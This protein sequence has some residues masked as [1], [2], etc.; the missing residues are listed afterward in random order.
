MSAPWLFITVSDESA[1]SREHL[2]A[3][4]ASLERQR[5]AGDLV[6]VMRGGNEAHP[7]HRG[8]V[9]V[10]TVICPLRIGA[11]QARNLGLGHAER[12]G[13]LAACDMVALPDDDARYPDGL[14]SHVSDLLQHKAAIVCGP[15]APN[16]NSLDVRR[17]P[18]G[19]RHLTPSLIMRVVSTNN[20]FFQARVVHAVGAFDERLGLGATYGSAE[21][22]DYALRAIEGGFPGIYD[23]QALVEHPYKPHRVDEYYRGNVAVLAKHARGGGTS[24]LLL[25]RLATG[26]LLIAQRRLRAAAYLRTVI[27]AIALGVGR[28]P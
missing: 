11:S 24:L 22:T 19:L 4:V 21:D 12:L 16:R 9:R 25:R 17:F 28:H 14:L 15:F 23:V 3:L 10:H 1:S 13:L 27:D 18:A 6:L 20:M 2:E 26:V 5:V 7:G 8:M